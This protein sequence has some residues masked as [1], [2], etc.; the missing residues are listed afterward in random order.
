MVYPEDTREIA[1]E[2]YVYEGLTLEQVAERTDIP[3]PTLKQW[4]SDGGWFQKKKEYRT[5]ALAIKHN[6][7]QLQKKLTE[8][9]LETLDPQ[10]VYALSRFRVATRK[11][12]A[13][14][15]KEPDIDRPR[16]FLEDM[17]FAV[18]ILQEVDPQALKLFGKHFGLIVRRFKEQH[19]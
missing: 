6:T 11:E 7:I 8:K 4:S 1:E 13:Q 10:A 14:D 2:T 5:A 3:M 19:N 9:A 15:Q 17:E 16:M 12:G 18:K